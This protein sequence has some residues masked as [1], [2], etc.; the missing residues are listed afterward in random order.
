MAKLLNLTTMKGNTTK[1]I[2]G[3]LATLLILCSAKIAIATGYYYTFEVQTV[4]ANNSSMSSSAARGHKYIFFVDHDRPGMSYSTIN[5]SLKY[6]FFARLMDDTDLAP[7]N[8]V[9]L[10][11]LGVELTSANNFDSSKYGNIL[12]DQ[13]SSNDFTSWPS[14]L[15][16]DYG[17][18]STTPPLLYLESSKK[19]ADKN[20][21]F[22]VS[23][24]SIGNT[25]I[26]NDYGEV[27]DHS[28]R[29]TCI[30]TEVKL[31]HITPT[32]EPTTLL[33]LGTG[34]AGLAA[35][36]R[37]KKTSSPPCA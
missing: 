3:S 13:Y 7:M 20:Y 16:Q 25:F 2:A 11:L 5:N 19:G 12:L 9:S 6:D 18:Q 15:G 36:N 10:A 28:V 8:P 22:G 27:N 4:L 23:P 29:F 17:W 14:Y 21:L 33:L 37:R 26:M 34:L 30:Q 35:A 31:T 24:L 32:P 1:Y